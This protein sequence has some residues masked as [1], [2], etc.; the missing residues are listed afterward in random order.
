MKGKERVSAGP[1]PAVTLPILPIAWS[2]RDQELAALQRRHQE[3][4]CAAFAL[5][6]H[7]LVVSVGT[8]TTAPQ[9]L[10]KAIT[11]AVSYWSD[12]ADVRDDDGNDRTT[13]PG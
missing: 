1:A 2:P 5:P 11:Y 3:A 9:R 4:I 6:A 13:Q 12:D 8:I 10:D 7:M